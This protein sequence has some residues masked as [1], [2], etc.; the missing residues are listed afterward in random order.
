[1]VQNFT[2]PDGSGDV[3]YGFVVND[4]NIILDNNEYFI[5]EFSG[6]INA[7]GD[8]DVWTGIYIDVKQS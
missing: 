7:S 2:H 5:C 1:M 4:L 3:Y 8:E 6:T